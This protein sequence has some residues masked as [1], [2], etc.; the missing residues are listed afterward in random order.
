M[1]NLSIL[2]ITL[3]L[4]FITGS[5]IYTDST[6]KY[7]NLL[8]DSV[9]C[10]SL[11]VVLESVYDADQGIR[12]K[13][14]SVKNEDF[15]ELIYQMQKIDSVNQAQVKLILN[16]YGW[17]PQ[18][19][20]SEKAADAIFFVVQ[21]ADME[22]IKKHLP[23]LKKLANNKEAKTTHAAMMEDRLLMYEGKK[24]IYGTQAMGNGSADG[25]AFIWPIQHPEKVNQLRKEAGF[26]LT[27]EENAKR[28]DAI[29]NPN[30]KLPDIK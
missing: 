10:D 17:L 5:C 21:H 15:G 20:I 26:E 28:L 3:C 30:E 22:L 14:S 29:Y 25:K 16:Q 8:Q 2:I 4:T 1:K 18:S 19:K 13:I 24:Q 27:V 12:K 7:N 11:R 23:D 6:I 9:R